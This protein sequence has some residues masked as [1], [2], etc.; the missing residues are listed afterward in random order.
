MTAKDGNNNLIEV[1]DFDFDELD[2][3]EGASE[4]DGVL[5][6]SDLVNEPIPFDLGGGKVIFFVDPSEFSPST[7]AKFSKVMKIIYKQVTLLEKNPGDGAL[8]TRVDRSM[9]KF[10]KM[11]LPDMPDDLLGE[12]SYGQKGKIIEWWTKKTNMSGRNSKNL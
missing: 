6:L 9:G 7:S 2:S 5:H 4:D 8:E 3:L 1:E 11:I 12:M 10:V